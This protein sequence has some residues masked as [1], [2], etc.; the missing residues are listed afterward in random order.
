VV[1]SEEAADV[2][3]WLYAVAS[4]LDGGLARAAFATRTCR[5]AAGGTGALSGDELAWEERV[6]QLKTLHG[7]LAAPGRAGHAA[8]LHPRTGP[9]GRCCSSRAASA[10]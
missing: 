8:P 2:L 4:P 5:P 6:E 7:D 9:A 3:R 1:E 10:A